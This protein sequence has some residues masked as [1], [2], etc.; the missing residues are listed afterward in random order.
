MRIGLP[1]WSRHRLAETVPTASVWVLGVHD[2]KLI[3]GGEFTEAGD[4]VANHV[5]AFDG[6][7]W[8]PMDGGFSAADVHE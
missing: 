1:D 6:T 7:A 2:D 4:R 8:S 3:A 5:A